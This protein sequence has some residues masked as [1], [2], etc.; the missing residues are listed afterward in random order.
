M[1]SAAPAPV[2]PIVLP[3]LESI[4]TPS[5]ALPNATAPVAS[6]PILLPAT[7][8]SSDDQE[9]IWTP[10]YTDA[11]DHVSFVA[12]RRAAIGLTPTQ[13]ATHPPR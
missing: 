13:L 12:D 1:T 4:S 6:V 11:R 8:L 5:L 7:T 9:S 2:P 10:S 3:E